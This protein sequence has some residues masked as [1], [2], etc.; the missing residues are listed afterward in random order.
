MTITKLKYFYI[1]IIIS[2]WQSEFQLM[3][4]FSE[5]FTQLDQNNLTYGLTDTSLEEIFLNVAE[6]SYDEGKEEKTKC[7][8]C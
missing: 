2:N 4:R 7:K 3:F 1:A 6:Q 5:L 8:R